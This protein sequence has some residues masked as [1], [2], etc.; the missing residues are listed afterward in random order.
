MCICIILNI[1]IP[2][3][4]SDDEAVRIFIEFSKVDTAIKGLY[5]DTHQS[6]CCA[7]G[8]AWMEL[9]LFCM[10]VMVTMANVHPPLQLQSV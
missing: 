9:V 10:W 8:P 3:G 7:V 1:Q 6:V 2:Q 4:V 5:V